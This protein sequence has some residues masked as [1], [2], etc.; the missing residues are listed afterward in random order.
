MPRNAELPSKVLTG[1][2]ILAFAAVAAALLSQ[3]VFGMLPCAWCIFQRLLFIVIG[4]VA[5]LGALLGFRLAQRASLAVITLLSLAGIA[6]A[7]HQWTVAAVSFSCDQTLADRVVAGS[8]L[9]GAMP[10]LF[11]IYATCM[12]AA[13]SVLGLDF[14]V[15]SLMLYTAFAVASVLALRSSKRS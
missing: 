11:G 12:D 10:W 1:I 9:D 3:H 5:A 13:V 8:G 15:W 4:I 6:A 2:A 7:W 14:A